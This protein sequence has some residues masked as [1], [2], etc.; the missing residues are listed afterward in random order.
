GVDQDSLGLSIDATWGAA[1]SMTQGEPS[2]AP[3]LW[4]QPL[5]L[6]S[7]TIRLVGFTDG[8]AGTLLNVL[9]WGLAVYLL[10]SEPTG[11]LTAAASLRQRAGAD[12]GPAGHRFRRCVGGRGEHVRVPGAD[13]RPADDPALHR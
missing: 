4:S 12:H 13:G 6:G 1:G 11:A 3:Q 5:A 2:T 8:T 7:H 9:G 10:G